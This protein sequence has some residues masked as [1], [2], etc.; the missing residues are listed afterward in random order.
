M[1]AK[2]TFYGIDKFLKEILD[3][4]ETKT[5][6]K[7]LAEIIG[8]KQGR[9]SSY[10]NDTQ[11]LSASAIHKYLK[12]IYELGLQKGLEEGQRRNAENFF[13]A[14]ESIHG[15]ENAD[16]SKKLI[17]GKSDNSKATS[18][19]NYRNGKVA[20]SK[21][22]FQNLLG[23]HSSKIFN[24]IVEFLECSPY[25]KGTSWKLFKDDDKKEKSICELLSNESSAKVG[26]YAMYDSSGRI[27]YFGKT[28]SG[29]YRE[30]TQRLGAA[31][32]RDIALVKKDGFKH[33]GTPGKQSKPGAIRVGEMTRYI[34]AIEVLA[35]E[36]ISNIE[37]FVLRLI[38]N[39]DVNYKI[40]NYE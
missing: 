20:I 23:K 28:N 6:Q 14:V 18:L 17:A 32:H 27:L 36:A 22:Q 19:S 35:P 29:L 8:E 5:S 24:P 15:F 39:D 40:E 9:Y 7:R 16:I 34:S 3:D 12:R 33:V 37:T 26:V 13:S 31:V 25:K 38:P 11:R 4:G 1:T 2:P 21:K 30:I 10:L